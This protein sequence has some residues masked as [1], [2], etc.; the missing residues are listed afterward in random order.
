M[1]TNTNIVSPSVNITVTPHKWESATSAQADKLT[2]DEMVI[3]LQT[4]PAGV[5]LPRQGLY[6][7]W[8][9]SGRHR[10]WPRQPLP[11]QPLSNMR[12]TSGFVS[13]FDFLL[14]LASRY[15]SSLCTSVG[16]PGKIGVNHIDCMVV[17][18]WQEGALLSNL[19]VRV[20]KDK[21]E[22][23]WGHSIVPRHSVLLPSSWLKFWYFDTSVL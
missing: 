1:A 12:K 21:W 10:S 15:T 6:S 9:I 5:T 16:W 7:L 18:V 11:H 20:S 4:G 3:W 22:C 13:C 2:A 19:L 14:P 23:V 17:Q 8:A